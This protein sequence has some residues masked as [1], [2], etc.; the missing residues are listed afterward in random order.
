MTQLKT[1]HHIAFFL[2]VGYLLG[3]G[4]LSLRPRV[5]AWYDWG[6]GIDAGAWNMYPYAI[7]LEET[8]Y[9][10]SAS[11]ETISFDFTPYLWQQHFI[12]SALP[13]LRQD[14]IDAFV[15]FLGQREEIQSLIPAGDSPDQWAVVFMVEYTKNG[16]VQTPFRAEAPLGI[17]EN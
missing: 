3:L 1:R 10:E 13:Y 16:V 17:L 11:G 12:S 14:K 9:L 5:D 8:A 4:F 15:N 2:F 7:E 6:R